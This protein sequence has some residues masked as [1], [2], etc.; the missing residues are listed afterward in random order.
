MARPG[1]AIGALFVAAT[2]AA[3]AV[4]VA[5]LQPRLAQAVHKVKQREDVYV[6]PPPREFKAMT[7]GYDAA[8]IDLLWAKLLI[9]YGT[10]VVEHR[11]FHADTYLDTVFAVE[12]TYAPLYKYADTFLCFRPQRGDEADARKTREL[13]EAGTRARPGDPEVWLEYGQFTAFLGPMFLGDKKE[14]REQWRH[15]GAMAM[16]K[17]AE[18]GADA[19]RALT[20]TSILE[21]YGELK[22][23]IRVLEQ[24]YAIVDD[25]LER[26]DI[27]RR[28]R[29]LKANEELERAKTTAETLQRV[30][31]TQWPF[32]SRYQCLLLGPPYAPLACAGPQASDDPA[33]AREW[34]DVL[35]TAATP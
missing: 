35:R 10:H 34:E 33:C 4:G 22:E 29:T 11:D 1:D 14:E 9:D 21:P 17:A 25:P 2:V 32:L 28:L 23:A 3:C 6:L 18:L 31:A 27:A 15:D 24:K 8:A 20:A 19:Q 26:E 7:L 30:C 16:L 12:P 13:L 5:R